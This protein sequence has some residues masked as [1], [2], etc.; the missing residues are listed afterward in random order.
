MSLLFQKSP[1]VMSP[2]RQLP[3]NLSPA[4]GNREQVEVHSISKGPKEA[5]IRTW[6]VTPARDF[7]HALK[8]GEDW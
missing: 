6:K 8:I 1:V 4:T 7:R 5:M 3:Q 2:K